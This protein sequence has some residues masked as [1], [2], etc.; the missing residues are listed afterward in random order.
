MNNALLYLGGILI[1]AL[2]VLFAVP[3]FIDWNSYR[4]VFEEEATRILGRE[5]RVGGDVNLR[6][7]PAPF[8]SFEKLRIS[9]VGDDGGNSII[10]A[11]SFTMWLSVPPLLRGVLE[12]HKV[13]LKRPVINLATN[14]EGTGNWRTLAITPGSFAFAPKEV[15]LQAVS[16]TD[17]AVIVS[18][19]T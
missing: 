7:L 18:G 4:G 13:E 15:A 14:A 8:V 1:T 17:G 6:L 10:R 11:E 9:D 12:A 5:V 2:A 3:R 16:I 19:P